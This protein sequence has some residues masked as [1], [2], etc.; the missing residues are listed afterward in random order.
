ML[1]DINGRFCFHLKENNSSATC[2][3][4]CPVTGWIYSDRYPEKLRAASYVAVFSLLCTLF[5]LCTLLV[6]WKK[7]GIQAYWTIGLAA[8]LSLLTTAFTIPLGHSPEP[9][10]DSITPNDLHTNGAC[11]LSG[12][13]LELGAM[14]TVVWSMCAIL[15]YQ[16]LNY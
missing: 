7:N 3:V 14:G 10:Y 1:T 4:P 5:V 13:M 2:C 12:A 9:C 6:G 11:A 15:S 16:S 8:S